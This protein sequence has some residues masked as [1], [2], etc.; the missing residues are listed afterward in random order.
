MSKWTLLEQNCVGKRY[1]HKLRKEETKSNWKEQVIL[2]KVKK[3]EKI[4]V[5]GAEKENK[6]DDKGMLLQRRK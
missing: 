2:T 5:E 4:T 1:Q 6:P 3:I